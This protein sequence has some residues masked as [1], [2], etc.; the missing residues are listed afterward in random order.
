MFAGPPSEYWPID[1]SV[2]TTRWQGTMSGTGLWPSAVPTARTARGRPISAATQPYGRTSPRGISSALD[3][4]STSNG[5]R[6]RRSRSMRARR[7]PSRRRR[8]A[9]SRRSGRRSATSARRPVRARCRRATSSA[10][11]ARSTIVT[12]RPFQATASGPRGESIVAIRSMR[13][14]SAR[15]AGRSDPGAGTVRVDKASLIASSV[16]MR[17]S[18]GGG[19]WL[20]PPASSA[21]SRPL[22]GPA[23]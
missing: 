7:S 15:T 10:S 13:P 17:S 9:D 14:T 16:L 19:R 22:G 12:P 1:P 2:R 20:P 21:A 8:I 11:A 18:P 5:V 4:T 23:P 3:Q 6:P